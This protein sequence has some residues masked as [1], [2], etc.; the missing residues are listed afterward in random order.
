M[1]LFTLKTDH[2]ARFYENFKK[3]PHHQW[4]FANP[5]VLQCFFILFD[6]FQEIHFKFFNKHQVHFIYSH[7]ELSFAVG[8]LKNE[9]VVVVFPDLYKMM[10]STLIT[11]ASATL[12]HELGHVYHQHH[13]RKLPN[14]DAQ[15]EAD[16][17]ASGLGFREDLKSTLMRFSHLKEI[18]YRLKKL[19]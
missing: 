9:S 17:F 1:E 16:R 14:I 13:K 15:V 19:N 11:E 12:A 2:K 5:K 3:N 4:I 10:N 7:A 6:E 18:Q 8:N